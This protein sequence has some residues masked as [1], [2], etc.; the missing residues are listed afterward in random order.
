MKLDLGTYYRAITRERG[1]ESRLWQACRN[2]RGYNFIA[3]ILEDLFDSINT[4]RRFRRG[5]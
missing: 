5:M 1:Q 2:W 3:P 4:I